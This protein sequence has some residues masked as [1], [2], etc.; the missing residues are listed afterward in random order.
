MFNGELEAKINPK[1]M[2]DYMKQEIFSLSELL[3]SGKKVAF[4]KGNRQVNNKN[5]KSKK[6]S[7][8][9]CVS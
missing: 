9:D 7:F 4:I 2:G 8:I 1:G 3:K 6:T 5:V